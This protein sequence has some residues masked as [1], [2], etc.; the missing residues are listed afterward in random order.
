[1]RS[2][3]ASRIESGHERSPPT[4]TTGPDTASIGTDDMNGLVAWW[5]DPAAGP[6]N[7]AADEL[8]ASEAAET[9][10]L[11]VRIPD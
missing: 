1:M 8:L 10:R 6:E 5:D 7:M 11:V 9:G 2:S 4:P 3:R